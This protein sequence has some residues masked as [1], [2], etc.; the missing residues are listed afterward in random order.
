MSPCKQESELF[1]SYKSGQVSNKTH[2]KS[3]KT[4]NEE[5]KRD[6]LI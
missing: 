3:V 5:S 6:S 2:N 4:I 1:K